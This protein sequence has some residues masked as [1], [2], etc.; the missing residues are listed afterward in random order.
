MRSSFRVSFLALVVVFVATACADPAPSAAPQ[1]AAP[2]PDVKVDSGDDAATPDVGKSD[3]GAPE[4]APDVVAFDA[5]ALDVPGD[6]PGDVAADVAVDRAPV[7]V[8]AT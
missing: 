8:S 4:D 3:V 2:A 6:A 1:D 7:C 5:A